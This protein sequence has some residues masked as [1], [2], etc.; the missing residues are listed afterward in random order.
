MISPVLRLL[1]F[2]IEP[3]WSNYCPLSSHSL[4]L[5]LSRAGQPPFASTSLSSPTIRS[6]E[7]LPHFI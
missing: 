2:I 4:W 1:H 7:L 3:F 6:I 5:R